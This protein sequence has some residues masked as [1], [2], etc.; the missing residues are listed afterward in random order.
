MERREGY[1]TEN[2]ETEKIFGRNVHAVLEFVRHE[3]PGKTPD[4]MSADYLTEEGKKRAADKGP[5]I[6]EKH[7]AA[8]ASTKLRAQETVDLGIQNVEEGVKVVNRKLKEFMGTGAEERTDGQREENE[9]RIKTKKELGVAENFSAILEDA[10]IW[11]NSKQAAGS[12]RS[13][14]DL[15]IQYYLDNEKVCVE[16]GITTPSEAAYQTAYRVDHEIRM[17]DHFLSESEIRLINVSHGPKLEP[18]LQRVLVQESGR[19]GFESLEEIGG[20]LEPGEKFELVV[21]IDN[22]GEKSV[23]LV[24]REKEYKI[25]LD[26]VKVLAD[27]YKK[28]LDGSK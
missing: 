21:D 11:A 22:E 23:V 16:R 25:D 15:I 2:K 12:D 6:R 10:T 1:S 26:R 5:V 24:F 18:F 28:S 17:T 8:F 7:V 9:F 20:A 4:G 13:M 3:V 14:Y 27:E 19:L